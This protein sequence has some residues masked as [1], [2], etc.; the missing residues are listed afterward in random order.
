VTVAI[1]YFVTGQNAAVIA[2]GSSV[3]LIF[4]GIP[5]N[6]YV[7]ERST[8]LTVWADIFTNPAA[9]NGLINA[10]D[11]FSDLG[12][13]PASAYYRLKWQP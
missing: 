8:N 2:S 7:I 11:N 4:H 13:V 12:V 3:A 1:N 5:N 10:T 6:N 9:T